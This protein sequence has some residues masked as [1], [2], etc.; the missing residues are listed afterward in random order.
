MNN[1]KLGT[2]SD[3]IYIYKNYVP[4]SV[5]ND[6]L[7][8]KIFSRNDDGTDRLE[9]ISLF[10]EMKDENEND[11]VIIPRYCEFGKQLI[12][13]D[14]L[15]DV[16]TSGADIN[17]KINVEPRNKYQ[18]NAIDSLLCHENGI[19]KAKTAFGKTYVAIHTIAKL[20]KK[21]LIFAH[22][23]DLVDQWKDSFIRYTNLT[24]DDIQIFKG[25]HFDPD[26]PITITTVQN[27]A[28]KVRLDK[29]FIRED[30][31]NANFGITFF[32]ECHT[33][34]GPL[35]NS[36]S[37]RWVFSRRLYGLSATPIRGD[38]YDKF[39]KDLIGDIIYNDDR[40]ML[41][42]FISFAPISINVPNNMKFYFSKAQKQ[43]TNRYYSWLAKQDE[44]IN[45][46]ANIVYSLIKK[47]KKILAVAAI[48]KLLEPIYE[49]TQNIL[50][51]NNEE[52][53]KIQLI[54]GTSE[55]KF[56]DIKNID[57]D[58]INNLSAIY[59]TNKFFSDGLS[60]EWLDTIVYFTS[61]SA[62]SLSAI[63]Q[64]VGR[65][66][67]DYEGKEYVNVIDIYNDQF[68][69]EKIRKKKR[70]ESYKNFDYNVL[71]MLPSGIDNTDKYIS[72]VLNTSHDLSNPLDLL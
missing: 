66:L 9:D 68:D 25:D 31:Y 43:Y 3:W 2:I 42:V 20:K 13:D 65:I 26:K 28:A 72:L 70:E 27:I 46:C 32:D 44:Y 64:L 23:S 54:H 48:K 41:P 35:I 17:I 51:D 5:L 50:R 71:S 8:I 49:K 63:P 39:I 6:D 40:E 53:N 24:E 29:S 55:S 1:N 52:I 7:H 69:I 30:F 61:P 57:I 34:I 4:S 11:I 59:S 56:E 19:L 38:N 45:F 12:K 16:R 18:K 60:I 37:T 33:S 21:A 10:D 36:Q 15:I 67:R 47:N 58:K 14:K 22:K 62:S